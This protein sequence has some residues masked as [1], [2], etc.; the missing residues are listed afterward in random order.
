[1][2]SARLTS[3]CTRHK[4]AL[5]LHNRQRVFLNRRW[6]CVATQLYVLMDDL[7]KINILKLKTTQQC[8]KIERRQELHKCVIIKTTG[9][10]PAIGNKGGIVV[11]LLLSLPVWAQ[12]IRSRFA[13]TIGTEYFCTGVGLV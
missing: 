8:V 9:T 4:I 13:R 11:L 12:A 1:M 3:L 10:Q 5:G 2:G 6:L 7:S